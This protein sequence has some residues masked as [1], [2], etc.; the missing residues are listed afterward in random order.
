MVR[1]APCSTKA[2]RDARCLDAIPI[3]R[4]IRVSESGPWLTIVGVVA[5]LKYSQLD[6]AA[7]PEVYVPYSRIGD[8]L[9]GL[10]AL[11]LTA[12]DPAAVTATAAET[13]TAT[14][15]G[16]GTGRGRARPSLRSEPDGGVST[17]S[18]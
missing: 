3:G 18:G 16:T 2:S 12:T 5:D 15:T 9:F 17:A 6:A 4:R 14:A 13:A 10:T 7:E 8:G 1:R 11:V